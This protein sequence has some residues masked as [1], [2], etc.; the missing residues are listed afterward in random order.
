MRDKILKKASLYEA[1]LK[2]FEFEN[3]PEKKYPG[4]N[5]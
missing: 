2:E 1:K 4:D 5:R 3:A